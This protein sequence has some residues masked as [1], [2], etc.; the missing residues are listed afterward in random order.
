M[1]KK[2]EP[3]LT[4]PIPEET[5]SERQEIFL[6]FVEGGARHN[7]AA[8]GDRRAPRHRVALAR[9]SRLHEAL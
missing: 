3:P 4:D 5:L 2:D 9:R 7:E 6:A 1:A 8:A